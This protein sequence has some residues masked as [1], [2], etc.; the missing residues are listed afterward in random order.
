MISTAAI[1]SLKSGRVDLVEKHF[2]QSNVDAS[3]YES[4]M[5]A[6]MYAASENKTEVVK[7]L[8]R[9]NADINKHD[10]YGYTALMRAASG[11]HIEACRVLLTNGADIHIKNSHKQTAYDI[12]VVQRSDDVADFL[13]G[14]MKIQSDQQA[15]DALVSINQCNES[16]VK[17]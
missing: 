2:N 1:L 13:S 11:N 8:L 10:V 15:L 14:F 12:S 16:M 3:L 9:I 4:G 7:F 17:F 6:L 5:T